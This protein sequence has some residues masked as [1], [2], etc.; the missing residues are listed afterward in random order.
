MRFPKKE[1]KIPEK[2]HSLFS[3][4]RSRLSGGRGV[5]LPEMLFSVLLVGYLSLAALGAILTAYRVTTQINDATYRQEL[6]DTLLERI[7]GELAD[8][9]IVYESEDS[10]LVGA[11]EIDI[12]S[13]KSIDIAIKTVGTEDVDEAAGIASLDLSPLSGQLLLHYKEK[14]PV[15]DSWWTYDQ[16]MYQDQQGNSYTIALAFTDL[17]MQKNS[18]DRPRVIKVKLTLNRSDGETTSYTSYASL[19]HADLKDP[20]G[21]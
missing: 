1:Q 11:K 16:D 17:N 15:E 19:Y 20:E 14:D 12:T 10:P 13:S 5:S 3:G 21:D 8:A 2:F 18:S 7:T 4:C 9:D 6:A